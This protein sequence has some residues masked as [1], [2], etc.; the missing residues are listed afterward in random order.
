M[1]DAGLIT[2]FVLG[3]GLD[4]NAVQSIMFNI[5]LARINPIAVFS[6]LKAKFSIFGWELQP[7][8]QS[9]FHCHCVRGGLLVSFGLEPDDN[10]PNNLQFYLTK[11]DPSNP[12]DPDTHI[13][14]STQCVLG[15][16]KFHQNNSIIP[17]KKFDSKFD[18]LTSITKTMVG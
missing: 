16:T 11:F 6:W 7:D 13:L 5:R 12:H 3:L 14:S 17:T 9:E 15:I 10:D 4:G 2:Y 18:F 8:M 1:T